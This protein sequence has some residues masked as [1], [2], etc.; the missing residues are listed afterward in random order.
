MTFNPWN[1]HPRPKPRSLSQ[2]PSYGPRV[3]FLGLD[4]SLVLVQAYHAMQLLTFSILWSPGSLFHLTGK[5]G[6]CFFHHFLTLEENFVLQTCNIVT[7]FHLFCRT[8][9]SPFTDTKI[10]KSH[11]QKSDL[12]STPIRTHNSQIITKSGIES[13]AVTHMSWVGVE[14]KLSWKT[15]LWVE[16]I[17]TSLNSSQLVTQSC[18]SELNFFESIGSLRVVN[19]WRVESKSVNI[20]TSVRGHPVN[21]RSGG[22]TV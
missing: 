20:Y 4:P 2:G 8:R 9:S 11:Y 12:L 6:G 19:D 22:W 5:W 7:F 3:D 17:P 1:G 14:L 18:K 21:K 13:W 15:L 16:E 10:R